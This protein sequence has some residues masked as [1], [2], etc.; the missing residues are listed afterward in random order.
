MSK[1][2]Y[3]GSEAD[4]GGKYERLTSQI[5]RC[6]HGKKAIYEHCDECSE[7]YE[8]IDPVAQYE[9]N[10]RNLVQLMDKHSWASELPPGMIDERWPTEARR[11]IEK[12]V[13]LY[14]LGRNQETKLKQQLASVERQYADVVRLLASGK[15]CIVINPTPPKD[16]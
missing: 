10:K 11:H 2:K 14:D 16:A 5:W 3:D 6:I 8:H 7:D 13:R 9:K 1:F 15:N 12:L 4:T